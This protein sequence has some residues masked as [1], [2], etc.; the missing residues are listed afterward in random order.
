MNRT[1][2]LLI[3][4]TVVAL[5][6]SAVRADDE[7]RGA[8]PLLDAARSAGAEASSLVFD[9]AV[10]PSAVVEKRRVSGATIL[11]ATTIASAALVTTAWLIGRNSG[12]NCRP[13]TVFSRSLGRWTS[14]VSGRWTTLDDGTRI[15]VPGPEPHPPL[16]PPGVAVPDLCVAR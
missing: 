16:L 10:S 2:T 13:D 14:A 15:V 7:P 11:L 1:L 12:A 4:A 6:A 8:G 3:V 5:S 9:E